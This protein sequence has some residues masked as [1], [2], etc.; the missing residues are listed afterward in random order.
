MWLPGMELCDSKQNFPQIRIKIEKSMKLYI[1]S[2]YFFF[3]QV[4]VPYPLVDFWS[5]KKVSYL[6]DLHFA[7]V[8]VVS[9]SNN[10]NKI[11]L[12][13][14]SDGLH[15]I[16]FECMCHIWSKC[17]A[18]SKQLCCQIVNRVIPSVTPKFRKLV[19]KKQTFIHSLSN[20]CFI[21]KYYKCKVYITS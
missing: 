5:H 21:N 11:F 19:G 6:F 18:G 7:V 1:F 13:N 14:V 15:S 8:F 2:Q 16:C 20:I 17:F 9:A 3:F 10:T 4:S 12:K